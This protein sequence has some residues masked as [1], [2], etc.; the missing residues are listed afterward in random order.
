MARGGSFARQAEEESWQTAEV[1]ALGRLKAAGVRVPE[2]RGFMDGVLLMDLVLTLEGEPAPRLAD[3][4]FTHDEAQVLYGELIHEVQLMLCA[5]IV[6]SDLSEYNILLAP[7]GPVIID[8]P[9]MVDAAAS[10]QARKLLIRD[11]SNIRDFCGKFAPEVLR[12]RYAEEMWYLYEKA[13]LTPSTVLTG[14]WRDSTRVAN[15]DNVRHA[16]ADAERMRR[17]TPGRTSGG[18]GGG[19]RGG[20]GGAPKGPPPRQAKSDPRLDQSGLETNF[21]ERRPPRNDGPRPPHPDGPRPPRN[22]GP[23]PPRNDG[24]R[25]PRNDGPRPPHPDGP[26]PPRNDGPRPP[27]PDGPRPPRNDGPRPPHPDGPRPPRSDGPRP[28]RNDG[29]RP[30]HPDGPRPPRTDGP[31]P[32]RNDGPRGRGPGGGR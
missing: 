9:Q 5:G 30:P 2:P 26:R 4:D 16:I 7:Y 31:R 24:P 20:P 21:D 10:G 14:E 3:C 32:P 29:P 22:D 25:P 15:V 1:T 28:P 11:V 19:P 27:H 13:T 23:R 6:H 8:L 12:T 18:P 17:P